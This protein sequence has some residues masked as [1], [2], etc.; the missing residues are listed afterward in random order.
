MVPD[1][2]LGFPPSAL[3]TLLF[4]EGHADIDEIRNSFLEKVVNRRDA[5][6]SLCNPELQQHLSHILGYYFWKWD[7]HFKIQDHVRLSG[8]DWEDEKDIRRA[9]PKLL[10]SDF[11]KSKSPWDLY[12]VFDVGLES[13]SQNKPSTCLIFRSH[14]ALGDAK[15][16]MKLLFQDWCGLPLLP[17]AS[18]TISDPYPPSALKDWIQFL[19]TSS[20]AEP[21]SLWTRERKNYSAMIH[22]DIS[23]PIP[24]SVLKD[25]SK[26]LRVPLSILLLSSLSMSLREFLLSNSNEAERVPNYLNCTFPIPVPGIRHPGRLTNHLYVNETMRPIFNRILA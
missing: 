8:W 16:L 23:K 22:C 18:T 4:L 24:L 13:G 15:S 26:K 2:R 19:H 3:L 25:L 6:G 12:V 5:A 1:A 11:E 9:V 10:L 17:P 20:L 21:E 14:H 7:D